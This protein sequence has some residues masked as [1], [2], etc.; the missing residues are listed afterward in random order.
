[1]FEKLKEKLQRNKE[2]PEDQVKKYT[3][4]NKDQ[5]NEWSQNRPDVGGNQ[6]AGKINMGT[7]G[8]QGVPNSFSYTGRGDSAA[9]ELKFPPEQK[10]PVK[11]VD[12]DSE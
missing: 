5:L 9:A 4:M 7:A 2:I 1:M 6:L 3:G 12:V 11:E 8:G 10:K